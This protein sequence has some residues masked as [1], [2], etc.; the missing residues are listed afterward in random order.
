MIQITGTIGIDA[1]SE[2]VRQGL[3]ASEASVDIYVDS[4]GGDV[5]E[6]NAMSLAIAE[7]ALRNPDKQYTCTIGSLCASAAANI[8][9]KL[10]T[11]FKVRAYRDTLLMYHSCSGVV[12]GNPQQ[13]KDM[14][15]MMELVN[16]SVIRSL[17]SKT[18]LDA[19]TVKSAFGTGRELWLDGEKA[20]AC[21]LVDELVDSEP[22][23]MEFSKDAS[24]KVLALVAKY[25]HSLEA[26]M[27]EEEKKEEVTAE[28]TV[29]V[30]A[31]AT[32]EATPEVTAEATTPEVV[33]EAETEEPK[34]EEE[35]IDWQAKCGELRSECD[36]LHKE[37]DALK[38]LVAKYQPTAQPTAQKAVKADWMAMV[39]ELNSKH[40][41]EQ[42]YARQ[43][44]ALKAEH[45]DAFNA[46]MNSHT[47]R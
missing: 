26:N 40:L 8:V 42:E 31:E 21:G 47:V 36:E 11:C 3:E 38:A 23:K 22:L 18:S 17:L 28:A 29:E 1:F 4:P 34:A 2:D 37:I 30:Q 35:E 32:P 19:T 43:Y 39:R 7:Y 6:S 5:V 41:P 24:L 45:M 10:P 15:V 12:E 13:L 9:A 14:S 25:K 33:A 20:V 46:F 27:N 16:E 44:S